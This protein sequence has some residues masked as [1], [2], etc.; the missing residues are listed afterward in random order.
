MQ[1]DSILIWIVANCSTRSQ[2]DRLF[3][4]DDLLIRTTL[5]WF[6]IKVVTC[7]TEWR[8]LIRIIKPEAIRIVI[9]GI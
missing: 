1:F 3:D 7:I 4:S 8:Y 2:S 5:I 6:Y 9:T